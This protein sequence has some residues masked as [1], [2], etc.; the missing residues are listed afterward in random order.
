VGRQRR[1]NR[2]FING[3]L[4]V[5]RTGAPWR[6]LPPRYGEW[7]KLLEMLVRAP[8]YEWLMIDATHVKVHRDGTGAKGGSQDVD[9]TKGGP[10]RRFIWPWMRMVCQSEPLSREVPSLTVHRLAALWRA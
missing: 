1:D 10:A 3:V 4:W 7:E 6:D 2:K 8:D 9:R 5:L